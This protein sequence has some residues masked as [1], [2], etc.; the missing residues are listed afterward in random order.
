[1]Y[2]SFLSGVIAEEKMFCFVFTVQYIKKHMTSGYKITLLNIWINNSWWHCDVLGLWCFI[3]ILCTADVSICLSRTLFL[4]LFHL[5]IFLMDES[6]TCL[7]KFG[8]FTK[9]FC[10][11][12]QTMHYTSVTYR[13]LSTFVVLKPNS[14]ISPLSL[15]PFFK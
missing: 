4:T 3:A 13:Q 14:S 11:A 5:C 7:F 1:M 10:W 6:N 8:C 12:A 15:V 9:W 2:S